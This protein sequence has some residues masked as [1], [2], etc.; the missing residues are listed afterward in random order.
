MSTGV[1]STATVSS[2]V[3]DVTE[4]V[5]EI[6]TGTVPPEPVGVP[7]RVAVPSPL[8]VNVNPAGTAPATAR[9]GA[10]KPDVSTVNVPDCPTT[11]AAWSALV[12]A[13]KLIGYPILDVRT[14]QVISGY[15][16]QAANQAVARLVELGVLQ[17]ITGRPVNRLFYCPPALALLTGGSQKA[18]DDLFAAIDP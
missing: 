17:E 16:F 4:L 14:A 5:A 15:T 11:N 13:E 1:T 9:A 12:I 7:A 10:G 6:V 8:S 3:A 2:C 18:V